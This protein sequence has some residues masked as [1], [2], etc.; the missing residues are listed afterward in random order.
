MNKLNNIAGPDVLS[1]GNKDQWFNTP[2]LFQTT[3]TS[4]NVQI[5][6]N[7]GN[8]EPTFTPGSF[9]DPVKV[10]MA[11]GFVGGVPENTVPQTTNIDS[12]AFAVV[13]WIM[14]H[15][16]LIGSTVLIIAVILLTRG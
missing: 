10:Q 9:L 2:P 3:Q 12:P 8:R 11:T 13:E 4:H 5:P 7:S 1:L 15:K 16:E 14:T 6:N